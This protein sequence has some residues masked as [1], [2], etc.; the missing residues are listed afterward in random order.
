M[1]IRA[2]IVA[3]TSALI[4]SGC[5]GSSNGEVTTDRVSPSVA[6]EWNEVLLTA[7]RGDFARPTVHARN[8]WH[9]SAA[10]YDA[11]AVFDDTAATWLLGGEQNGYSCD[12]DALP[13]PDNVLKAREEAIS[14]AA[15]QLI[16]YRF[17]R[18]IP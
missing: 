9:V 2:G 17:R 18:G 8:L 16:N 6:R 3:V 14:H 4:I 7:I 11:W 12:L 5:G 15:Y 10:M 13:A 1:R